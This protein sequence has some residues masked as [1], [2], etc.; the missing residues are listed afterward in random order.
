MIFL[1]HIEAT[2]PDGLGSDQKIDDPPLLPCYSGSMFSR[3]TD[4]QWFQG[5]VCRPN[6]YAIGPM[7]NP[8]Q[9]TDNRKTDSISKESRSI[10]PD[11]PREISI[12]SDDRDVSPSDSV[13][14]DRPTSTRSSDG[15]SMG[16]EGRILRNG[17]PP[18][19]SPFSTN[20]LWIRCDM[21]RKHVRKPSSATPG[22]YDLFDRLDQRALSL[23]QRALSEDASRISG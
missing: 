7:A 11:G 23:D 14:I 1:R 21:R 19:A 6:A 9:S 12:S 17:I 13:R 5:M 4:I 10:C 15:A 18:I 20:L 2:H 22:N 8:K 3:C 16:G